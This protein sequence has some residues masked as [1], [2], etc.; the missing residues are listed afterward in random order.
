[1][2]SDLDGK[3]RPLSRLITLASVSNGISDQQI[4]MVHVR[5]QLSE[6]AD[7]ERDIKSRNLL[8]VL[9]ITPTA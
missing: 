1:M 2:I 4:Q 7:R 3:E 5:Y 6:E 9:K 8:R